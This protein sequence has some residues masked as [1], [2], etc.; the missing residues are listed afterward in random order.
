VL[1]KNKLKKL[2]LFT[3]KTIAKKY[4]KKLVKAEL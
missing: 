2:I 3:L 1:H 4:V